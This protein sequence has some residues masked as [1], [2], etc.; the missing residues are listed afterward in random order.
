LQEVQQS[1]HREEVEVIVAA[2]NASHWNRK[3]A[4]KR[5]QLDYKA[6]LYKMKKLGIE[7][8]PDHLFTK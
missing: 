6:L 5:L 7:S 2:L 8:K 1:K 3:H 4:A